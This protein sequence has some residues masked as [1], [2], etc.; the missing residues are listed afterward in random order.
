MF[1]DINDI[2]M[3]DCPIEIDA[4]PVVNR[5][6][7]E[8][9]FF[10]NAS[11][12]FEVGLFDIIEMN[13][14]ECNPEQETALR[15]VVNTLARRILDVFEASLLMK[16]LALEDGTTRLSRVQIETFI[17]AIREEAQIQCLDIHE[18]CPAS[19]GEDYVRLLQ[20]IVAELKA[21]LDM[22]ALDLAFLENDI[23]LCMD[24][25]IQRHVWRR[26]RIETETHRRVGEQIERL[27]ALA[28]DAPEGR[29][30]RLF[31]IRPIPLSARFAAL[32][33]AIAVGAPVARTA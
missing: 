31:T 10:R 14:V 22:P 16:Q 5:L 2:T 17:A 28:T 8:H 24:T 18:L 3:A 13:F 12:S 29:T 7:Q 1:T 30:P 15:S 32:R 20:T 9:P 6:F 25:A 21:Y 26:I 11:E 33:G 19:A 27:L 23:R 4:L